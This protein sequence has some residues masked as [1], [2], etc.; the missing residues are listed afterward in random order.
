MIKASY[1]FSK[2]NIESLVHRYGRQTDLIFDKFQQ[3]TDEEANLRLAKAE[4]WYGIHHEMILKPLDFFERRTGRLY[5]DPFE[6]GHLKDPILKE[7]SD[8]FNWDKVTFD[9]EKEVL[10]KAFKEITDFN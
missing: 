8:Y 2:I 9:F 6:L 10:E 5:F 4:L 3:I 1:G 7:F